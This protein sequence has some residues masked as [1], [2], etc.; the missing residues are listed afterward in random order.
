TTPTTSTTPTTPTTP[1][2]TPTTPTTAPPVG[3][4]AD[5]TPIT[6]A[7][8]LDTRLAES[9]PRPIVAGADRTVSVAGAVPPGA[10]AVAVNVTVT[11]PTAD[12]F[13]SVYPTGSPRPGTS[14]V[15]YLPGQTVA[16]SVVVKLGTDLGLDVH[17]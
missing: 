11:D 7:R 6:P 8:I 13:A 3:E 10:V 5:F 17:V 2:T 9:G 12:A 14:V 15:N 16:N 4:V 1:S